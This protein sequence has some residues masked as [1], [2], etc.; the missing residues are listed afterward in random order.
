VA[1]TSGPPGSRSPRTVRPRWA[2]RTSRGSGAALIIAVVF[3]GM[4]RWEPVSAQL[5]AR[6]ARRR[7]PSRYSPGPMHPRPSRSRS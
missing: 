3:A 4:A 1:A 5:G 6:A 2:G 7:R